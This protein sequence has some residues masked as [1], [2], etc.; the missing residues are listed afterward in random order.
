MPLGGKPDKHMMIG[1][2]LEDLRQYRHHHH[3][4][5]QQQK[6]AGQQALGLLLQPASS[7]QTVTHSGVVA[8][9]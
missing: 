6:R 2:G 9:L 7:S 8:L 4:Q 3:H 1:E 5:Q